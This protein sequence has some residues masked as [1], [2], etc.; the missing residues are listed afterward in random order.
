MRCRCVLIECTVPLNSLRI[1][2]LSIHCSVT[3]L[4]N[5]VFGVNDSNQSTPVI[6]ADC[7]IQN[8]AEMALKQQASLVNSTRFAGVNMATSC[9]VIHR[10][11]ALTMYHRFPS[12][13][14]S[15]S[16][17]T[18]RSLTY[19]FQPHV[20]RRNGTSSLL[21]SNRSL[22]YCSFNHC[23]PSPRY[24]IHQYRYQ[25]SSFSSK[26]D[27]LSTDYY[28]V[29]GVDTQCSIDDIKKAYRK[30][31]LEHHP[32]RNQDD[33]KNAE[34]RFKNISAAYQVP[35]LSHVIF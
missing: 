21:L 35:G 26:A 1:T 32:D 11:P 24:W 33:R 4:V 18:L 5:D 3:I 28:K 34:E 25:F 30:L 23:N 29:L 6:L 17:C 31:A 13:N 8:A 19:P 2:S 10:K 20:Y 9:S 15:R 7:S 12:I 22:H 14:N 16:M 27:P